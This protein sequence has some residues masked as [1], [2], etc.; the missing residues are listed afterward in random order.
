VILILTSPYCKQ[1]YEF[2]KFKRIYKKTT[3]CI[4]LKIFPNML[5]KTTVTEKSRF[6]S[7]HRSSDRTCRRKKRKTVAE[8]K[9]S[10]SANGVQFDVGLLRM[11]N[12]NT[13][14]AI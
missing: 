4:S 2:I 9:D 5:I 13:W 7:Q 8:T 1:L 12:L 14:S 6:P 11:T 3:A 10:S